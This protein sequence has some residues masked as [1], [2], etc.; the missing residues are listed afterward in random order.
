MLVE[1]S[2]IYTFTFLLLLVS[3]AVGSPIMYIFM[4]VGE[5]QVRAVFDSPQ[6][7]ASWNSV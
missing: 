5:T 7:T 3:Y 1:S 2:A 4:A 6:L